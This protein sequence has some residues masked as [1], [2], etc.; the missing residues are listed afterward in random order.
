MMAALSRT[1]A[2]A[3]PPVTPRTRWLIRSVLH[4]TLCLVLGWAGG[5]V[6]AGWCL[7]DTLRPVALRRLCSR[8]PLIAGGTHL[9]PSGEL[10]L[11]SGC[12]SLILS[13]VCALL[14][15]G[16]ECRR[17]RS[18]DREDKPDTTLDPILSASPYL[19]MQLLCEKMTE[20][21]V[22]ICLM[23]LSFRVRRGRRGIPMADGAP[24]SRRPFGRVRGK[25]KTDRTR[26]PVA[27]HQENQG[28]RRRP[29]E[30]Y[31]WRRAPQSRAE[32]RDSR[33]RPRL[34]YFLS[35]L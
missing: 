22:W 23:L 13:S 18:A 24:R 26:N 30:G 28:A 32:R 1:P 34:P 14:P 20:L 35:S 29:V 33:P 7:L 19:E 11:R 27:R 3:T 6:H 8:K 9:F 12:R 10:S 16:A 2:P 15:C 4:H 25:R 21:P 5:L 17:A 31:N